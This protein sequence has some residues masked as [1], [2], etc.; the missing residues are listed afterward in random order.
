MGNAPPNAYVKALGTAA[1]RLE[2]EFKTIERD[3][4]EVAE[5]VMQIG[6]RAIAQVTA[7]LNR[8]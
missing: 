7:F 8:L 2:S 6:T 3:A 5:T 1:E 4:A